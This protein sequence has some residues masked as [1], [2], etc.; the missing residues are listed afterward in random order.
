[1]TTKDVEL[2]NSLS[3]GH[4]NKEAV[5]IIPKPDRFIFS[6]SFDSDYE[7]EVECLKTDLNEFMDENGIR[8]IKDF[9]A[10]DLSNLE[11]WLNEKNNLK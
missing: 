7:I 9:D 5:F 2:L 10:S 4:F 1:M 3:K 8:S 6:Y 11:D